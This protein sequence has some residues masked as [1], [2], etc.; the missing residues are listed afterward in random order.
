VRLFTPP[1][2][3]ELA[4]SSATASARPSPPLLRDHYDSPDRDVDDCLAPIY[5]ARLRCAEMR[6]R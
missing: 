6:V 3:F 1:Y 4:I 5:S 2:P